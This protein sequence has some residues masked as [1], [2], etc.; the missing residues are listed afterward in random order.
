MAGL[1][2][3]YFDFGTLLSDQPRKNRK[4]NSYTLT[5]A[6]LKK[7]IQL[8]Q[9][10]AADDPRNSFYNWAEAAIYGTILP[11][12]QFMPE[13]VKAVSLLLALLNPFLVIVYLVDVV[14]NLDKS[15]FRSVLIRAGII[16]AAVYSLF[17][18]AGDA[19]FTSIIQADFA[20]FQIF[21][22]IVFL[23]IGLQFVFKG[24]STIEILR[25]E[26]KH[27]VGAIAMPVLIGPGTLSASVVVGKS[28]SPL[29]ACAAIFVAMTISIALMLVL[30]TLHDHAISTRESLV[31][32]YIEIAGRVTALYVGTIAVQMIMEGL[33]TWAGKF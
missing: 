8:A 15:T 31:Q 20:S 32:R 5:D 27:L 7:G 25:G 24:P 18:I 30:K 33:H 19:I 26:S 11:I 2:Y 21:G 4:I 14:Q 12:L 16:S 3:R 1:D 23:A 17:A 28:L 6:D 13:F 29:L 10:G 9:N 22:G